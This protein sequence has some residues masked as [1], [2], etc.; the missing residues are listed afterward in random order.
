VELISCL[1]VPLFKKNIDTR[2]VKARYYNTAR[3]G[4]AVVEERRV[5]FFMDSVKLLASETNANG[6]I[7]AEF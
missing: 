7:E 6:R 2:W 4:N 1:S 5:E 3:T